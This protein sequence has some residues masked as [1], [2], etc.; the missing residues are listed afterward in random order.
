[1][2]V[3]GR[4]GG[5]ELVDVGEDF[6]GKEGSV[7]LVAVGFLSDDLESGKEAIEVE[8]ALGEGQF[9]LHLGIEQAG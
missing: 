3:G 8:L 9:S 1:M 6:G 4:A 7:H 5:G 2:R